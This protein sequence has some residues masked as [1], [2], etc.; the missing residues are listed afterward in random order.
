[1]S[2]SFGP[3]VA[4][5]PSAYVHPSVQA[6]GKI[7]IA[8]GANLWANV[9][10]RAEAFDVRIGRYTNIQD[11]TMIHIGWETPSIIGDYCSIT[12]HSTIHGCTIGNHCLIGINATVMDG[13]VIGDNCIV[14]QHA[15]VKNDMV[16]PDNS[17]VVGAPAK[18]IRTQN[19]YV[20]NKLNAL[21]YHRNAGAYLA[22]DHRAWHGPDF[23]SFLSR[24]RDRLERE[25]EETYGG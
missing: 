15:Y 4:I 1:M 21:L 18:V 13:A 8:E 14:G 20:A 12:H 7:S 2:P 17:V 16:V 10:I 25:F 22:G 5:D 24:E 9:V 11:F 3:E 6:Y 23:E 19:S